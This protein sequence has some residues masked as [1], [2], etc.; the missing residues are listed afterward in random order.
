MNALKV[1]IKDMVRDRAE[2]GDG[3]QNG[4]PGAQNIG[5]K[6]LAAKRVPM[7]LAWLCLAWLAFAPG[8]AAQTAALRATNKNDSDPLQQFN[9][10]VRALVNRVTPSVV[11]VIVTGYGPVEGSHGATSLVI[12]RQQSIGSGVI[13]DSEGY[14]LTNA[15]VIRG[16]HRV[17]VKIPPPTNDASPD[18]SL[19]SER[20][21]TMDASI[22]GSD[23]DID[24]ALLKIEAKGLPA[25]RLSDYNKLRQG[26]VV[27][28]FGSP[29][30]LQD[31]VT[32]GVVSSAAR[33]P[34]PDSPM[35]FVQS[36]APINPGSSGGAL[37]SVDGEVVGI[38]TFIL[39]EGG[40]NEGLGF[41]IPSSIVAFAYPQLRK[42]GHV[43]RGETG[44]AVQA[45]SPSLAAGLKLPI[46]WGVI[47]S[48]V[49][50]GSPADSAGLK[51][52]DIITSIDGR[53]ADNLPALGTRLFMR[54]GGERIKLGVLR[55]SEKLSF[56]VSVVEMAHDIDRL[57][58]LADPVKNLVSK[59]GVVAVEIDSRIAPSLSGLRTTSG[60]IVAARSADPNVD[61]SLA[62][63]DVIHAINGAS[64]TTIED[65]R[66]ALDRL[67]PN[68]P[69]VLQI[70][71]QG[72]LMFIPFK[73]DGSD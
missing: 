18:Q 30:G 3:M 21:R 24:L 72:K 46:D 40:G 69:V 22:V 12:G 25:L 51:I 63:G 52:Q 33:Q 28:A 64:V 49:E 32:M 10:S 48:D 58:G 26:D 59:L 41:A 66:S 15:H 4:L 53:S 34:D 44:I 8:I 65:L 5:N 27:F 68:S 57:A 50:P 60:V 29:E 55:G 14:I 36:D 17:Q 2:A 71:R 62:A 38:N 1:V 67:S 7:G 9:S 13:V 73:L 47:I 39:T 23:S 6:S 43:H 16:A 19:V 42:Y 35:V 70:E 61:V 20:G 31:S 45:I 37:V 11:Q 54:S 56:D